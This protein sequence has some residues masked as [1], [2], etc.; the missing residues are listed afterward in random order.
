MS[1]SLEQRRSAYKQFFLNT[2]AGRELLE[3]AKTL[4]SNNVHKAQNAN[5]LDFLSRS[6]GN[7]EVIDL[8]ENVLNTE[9][10]PKE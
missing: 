4:E 7:R 2:D 3:Q 9:V 10:K 8:I 6:T 5:S 1:L